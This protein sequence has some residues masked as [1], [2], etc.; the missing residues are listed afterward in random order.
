MVKTCKL[1][2]KWHWKELVPRIVIPATWEAEIERLR[3]KVYLDSGVS[4]RAAWVTC[5]T[6]LK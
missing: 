5:K 6:V 1:W 4:S 3:V 2:G